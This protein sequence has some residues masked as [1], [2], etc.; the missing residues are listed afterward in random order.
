MTTAPVA[1]V[2]PTGRPPRRIGVLGAAALGA[3]LADE[4]VLGTVREV[5]GAVSRRVRRVLGRATG[6]PATP[7]RHGPG[8]GS[9][10][11]YAAIGAS[12]GVTSQ[13]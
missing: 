6:L 13:A 3:Q 10:M 4:L 2:V 7:S 1:A 8:P 11:V 9:W 12:L 5:H